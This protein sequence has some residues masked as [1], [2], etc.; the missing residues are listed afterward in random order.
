MVAFKQGV[1]GVGGRNV[2]LGDLETA[3]E[4]IPAKK[5]QGANPLNS[6]NQ[7]VGKYRGGG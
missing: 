4:K 7:R 6:T 1:I 3:K 2:R 5:E